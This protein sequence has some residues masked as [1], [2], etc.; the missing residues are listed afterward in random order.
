VPEADIK[1]FP[2]PL[3]PLLKESTVIWRSVFSEQ[4]APYIQSMSLL[5]M[6]VNNMKGSTRLCTNNQVGNCKNTYGFCCTMWMETLSF[7]REDHLS[8][9]KSTRKSLHGP[10]IRFW[11]C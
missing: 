4:H 11:S 3:P 8:Q 9:W 5:F 6:A 10:T 1:T 7:G 2:S